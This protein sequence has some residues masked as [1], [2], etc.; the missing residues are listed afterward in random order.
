MK[1]FKISDDCISFEC[2]AKTCEAADGQ[3]KVQKAE[4]V[5][6]VFSLLEDLFREDDIRLDNVRVAAYLLWET[7]YPEAKPSNKNFAEAPFASSFT[8]LKQKVATI[9]YTQAYENFD[10]DTAN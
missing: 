9:A 6:S 10:L 8:D 5:A 7:L 2:Q 1:N 4:V 3:H